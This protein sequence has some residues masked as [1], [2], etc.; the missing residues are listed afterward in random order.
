MTR[1]PLGRMLFILTYFHPIVATHCTYVFFSFTNDMHIVSPISNV[2]LVFL[3]L[4]AKF[5]TLGLSI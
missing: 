2:V 5:V 1:D 3:Q 4:Y